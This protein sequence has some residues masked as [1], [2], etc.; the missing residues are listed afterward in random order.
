MF[1]VCE[2][3]QEKVFPA[4]I[5]LI[6][7]KIYR[8]RGKKEYRVISFAST[9]AA[10]EFEH[11]CMEENLPG[12]MIP[13]P[14]QVS[15]GCGLSWRVKEEEFPIMEKKLSQSEISFEKITKLMLF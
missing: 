10:M 12:R 6:L 14:G 5:G 15:A 11:W 8:M 13:T 9:V 1:R 7:D 3:K 2:G 4:C